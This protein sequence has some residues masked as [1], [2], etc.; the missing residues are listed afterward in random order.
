MKNPVCPKVSIRANDI[1][2]SYAPQSHINYTVELAKPLS[3][4]NQKPREI[5]KI[6]KIR[7]KTG[8]INPKNDNSRI[9]ELSKS[10]QSNE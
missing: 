4:E 7:E 10:K 6:G 9:L 2:I 8:Q 3:R 5:E 1:C